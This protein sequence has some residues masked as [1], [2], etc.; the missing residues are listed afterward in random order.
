M[1]FNVNIT[2]EYQL[3]T[4]RIQREYGIWH[5]QLGHVV[6]MKGWG[7]EGDR[8]EGGWEVPGQFLNRVGSTKNRET[9]DIQKVFAFFKN[10]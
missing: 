10:G 1:F 5:P 2:P 4:V 6:R 7:G 3:T 9:I 8:E